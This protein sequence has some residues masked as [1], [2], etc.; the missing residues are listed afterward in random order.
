MESKLCSPGEAEKGLMLEFL[1]KDRPRNIN[2]INFIKNYPVSTFD[3]RGDSA[4]IRGK[5]DEDWVYISSESLGE[6][7]GLLE[8]LDDRDKCFAVL[9]DWMLP[10]IIRDSAVRSRL[11]SMKLVY[12][13]ETPLPP[14]KCRAVELKVPDAP[15]VYEN[16]KYKEYI[17]IEYI[18]DRIKNGVALG[19]TA[20]GK[21]VAWAITHD[22]GAIGFLNVLEEYRKN[23]YGLDVTV[24]MMKRLLESG[25]LP[26]VHIEETNVKS[27]N[28]AL[29]AGFRKDRRIHWIKL[30]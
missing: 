2:I 21:L 24:S 23:G 13:G 4:L 16:S 3:R 27:M 19:I 7:M 30:G 25:E 8:G 17:S 20:D 12:D 22:D 14:Q 11:T 10:Y 26:F 28:L 18:E 6:F 5:S 29:K 15:Y 1:R 9:E